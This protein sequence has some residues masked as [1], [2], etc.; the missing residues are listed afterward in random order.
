MNIHSIYS[1]ISPYFRNKRFEKFIDNIQPKAH[2]SILDVGGYPN[3]WT[4]QNPC[5]NSIEI[6]NIHQIN[7]NSPTYAN[8]NIN[9]VI[10]NACSLEYKNNCFDIVF[11]NSVIEHVSS[12]EN[13]KK[14]AAEVRRVGKRL[15]IQTPAKEFFIEPHYITPFIHWLPKNIRIYF[16]KYFTVW[17]LLT[18][19]TDKKIKEML[20]EIR[21]LSFK[22]MQQLFPDC[23]IIKEPFFMIFTKSYIAFRK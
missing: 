21:L 5:W 3:T 2:E 10:G 6:L 1:K 22:E 12:W 4:T 18:K 9:T 14:F 17:G 20:N 19:P 8:Y 13:Q 16:L 23:E 15:W 11:S 7:H